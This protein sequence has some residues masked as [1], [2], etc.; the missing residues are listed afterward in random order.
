MWAFWRY[1]DC[2][3]G[4]WRIPDSW[5]VYARSNLG[6]GQLSCFTNLSKGLGLAGIRL[7][8][9]ASSENLTSAIEAAV[10]V[11]TPTYPSI[12]IASATLPNA[13]HFLEMNRSKTEYF[14]QQMIGL[15]SEH[16]IEVVGTSIS[17]PIMLLK[18]EELTFQSYLRISALRHVQ[19]SI[20]QLRATRWLKSMFDY[21][22]L[23]MMWI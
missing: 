23:E 9:L 12:K 2:R 15:L 20:L 4:L 17:T 10:S 5:T 7:G 6:L 3:R 1:F 16:N 19:V 13:K 18:R 11:F 22:L 8:Y 21:E 14:K